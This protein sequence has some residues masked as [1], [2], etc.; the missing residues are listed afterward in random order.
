MDRTAFALLVALAAV[1]VAAPPATAQAAERAFTI[2]VFS[3]GAAFSGFQGVWVSPT[4]PPDGGGAPATYAGSLSGQA[5]ATFGAAATY[6]F[7]RG[8]ALRAQASQAPSQLEV[9]LDEEDL[10]ALEPDSD[11][12]VAGEFNDMTATLVDLSVLFRLPASLGPIVPYA[13]VGL[14]AVSYDIDEAAPE[15]TSLSGD[16]RPGRRTRLAGVLGLGAIVPLQT[17][18]FSLFFELNDYLT[19]TPVSEGGPDDGLRSAMIDARL[20]SADSPDEEDAPDRISLT[21]NVRFTAGFA[22]Q[23]GGAR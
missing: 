14:G 22:F 9:R 6:W 1:P 18:E 21:S 11:A 8:W 15:G 20:V 3:G 7:G 4:S 2:S 16:L 12:R 5:A 17:S 10:D 19:P 23:I 13:V